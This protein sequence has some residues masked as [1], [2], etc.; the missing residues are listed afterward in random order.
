MSRATSTICS[1][2]KSRT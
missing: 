1:A 2:S